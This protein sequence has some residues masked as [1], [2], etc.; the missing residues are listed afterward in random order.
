M[1]RKMVYW[2]GMVQ[3]IIAIKIDTYIIYPIFFSV[4]TITKI[5]LNIMCKIKNNVLLYT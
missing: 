1:Q 5:F 3:K 2:Y 4:K